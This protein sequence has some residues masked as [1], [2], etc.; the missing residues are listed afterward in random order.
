M[1]QYAAVRALACL[2]VLASTVTP[3]RAAS[4]G[5]I[6]VWWQPSGDVPAAAKVRAAFVEAAARRGATVI[7]AV[8]KAR[9]EAPLS[10]MLDAAL[11]DYAAFRFA[12][13]LAKLDELARTVDA[14]GGGELDARQLSE[15]YL[16][17]ALARLEV[18]PPEAAWDDL[19]R[20]ARLDPTRVLDPARF[21]PRVVAAYR[22]AATEATELP[23]CE[24]E[25]V[26]PAGAAVR[27][28]GRPLAGL[29]TVAV[30]QHLVTVAV[31]GTHER[32]Q[33][34]LRRDEPPD[35]D[36]LVAMTH[37]RTP[38]HI[39]LGAVAAGEG[40]WRFVARTLTP[41]DGKTL[42]GSAPL[43]DMPAAIVVERVLDRLSPI[44][45]GVVTVEKP[46]PKRRWW[47]WAAVAGGVAATLL[48]VIP[49][50]VVYGSSSSSGQIGGT[51][52]R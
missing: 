42:S 50:S 26:L 31:T 52:P 21:Q 16:Y 12:D 45:P 3:S 27:L 22:R 19:V 47:V 49:V 9:H 43:D 38:A 37:D 4:G 39:L 1:I 17:R 13:A 40:G 32:L 36:A 2:I 29:G 30:G 20:A 46:A 6:A 15:V 11:A 48:V 41:A 7:D 25:L 24:L 44:T 34:P 8:V 18:G 33:P 23:R 28:D 5:T 10:P 51:V 14:R 35:A